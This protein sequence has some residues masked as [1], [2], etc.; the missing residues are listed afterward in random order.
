MSYSI[1]NFQRG[2]HFSQFHHVLQK[3]VL[4]FEHIVFTKSVSPDLN[5]KLGKAIVLF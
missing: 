1:Y 5:G 2:S 4:L 3:Q